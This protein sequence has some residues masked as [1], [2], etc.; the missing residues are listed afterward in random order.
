VIGRDPDLELFFDSP[1]VSRRHA[2]ISVTDRNPVQQRSMRTCGFRSSPTDHIP[3]SLPGTP[4][5][6][7]STITGHQTGGDAALDSGRVELDLDPWPNY[8]RLSLRSRMDL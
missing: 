8:D 5:G 1:S 7:H 3:D 6:D 2:L 4:A